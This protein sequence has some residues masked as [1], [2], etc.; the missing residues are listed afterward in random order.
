VNTGRDFIFLAALPFAIWAGY[1]HDSQHSAIS[2]TRTQ[3]LNQVHWSAPVDL[4]PQGGA[5]LYI[6]YGSPAVTE[7]NTILVPVKTGATD[8][9]E[10][11]ARSGATGALLYTLPTDYSLPPHM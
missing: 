8:G 4:N 1:G 11:Q 10:V 7:E 9:F 5:D 3:P 2:A 6:H